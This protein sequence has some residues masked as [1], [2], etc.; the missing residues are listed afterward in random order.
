MKTFFDAHYAPYKDNHRYW[1]GLLL[2][3]RFLILLLSTIINIG[4]PQDP[5][6]NLLVMIVVLSVLLAW[7]SRG[8]YKKW[9]LDAL[10]ASF[11]FN[12][13]V[14]AVGTYQVR[15]SG[16]SQA[17]LVYTSVGI[18]FVTFLGIVCGA[19]VP[20]TRV[21]KS[22]AHQIKTLSHPEQRACD[23]HQ[24]DPTVRPFTPAVTVS[25]VEIDLRQPCQLAESTSYRESVIELMTS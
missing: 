18:A 23:G 2:L 11:I 8:V 10:E 20:K 25:N 16:G 1:T 14:L 12:L 13:I 7:V 19:M 4:K 6:T 22:I 21:G 5:H 15:L 17:A 3:V 24:E 9:Y